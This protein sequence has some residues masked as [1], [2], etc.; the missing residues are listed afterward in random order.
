MTYGTIFKPN[1]KIV[2]SAFVAALLFSLPLQ[3]ASVNQPAPDFTAKTTKGET[4]TLSQQKGKLVVLEWNN[5]DCPFV[6][7]HYD[8]G[9]MQ[10]LQ[11][12]Y[13]G[14]G[15]VWVSIIS[16]APGKQG[17]V[18]DDGANK[19]VTE[20]NAAPTYVIRDTDGK[21]GKL[22]DAKTTPHMF[23]INKEGV[24]NYAGAID[25]IPS[26]D[27]ADV[28]KAQNYVTAALEE[29]KAGKPITTPTSRPYGCNVKY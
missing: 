4:F 27:Q 22:Y 12:K 28:T 10:T 11:K 13:T 16:S 23:V 14:E 18:E 8:S 9:N 24:L 15:V 6:K 2:L 17:Y 5:N 25:S 29:V 21:I 26:A 7:K 1:R 19:I 3:A 20:R